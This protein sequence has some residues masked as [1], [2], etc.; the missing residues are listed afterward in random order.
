[1]SEFN[2][3]V[4]TDDVV[5]YHRAPGDWEPPEPPDQGS[6]ERVPG[7]PWAF[8]CLFQPCFFRVLEQRFKLCGIVKIKAICEHLD[9]N[10]EVNHVNDCSGCPLR[11]P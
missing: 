7:N 8:R 10:R 6:Y 5:E 3:K 11:S 9:I 2:L 1:M 4:V